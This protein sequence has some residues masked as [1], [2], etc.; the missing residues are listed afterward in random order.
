MY[1]IQRAVVQLAARCNSTPSSGSEDHIVASSPLDY[2]AK[3]S[4]H[5]TKAL[6]IDA[7]T[8]KRPYH[9]LCLRSQGWA[10]RIPFQETL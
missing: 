1:I 10:S 8:S 2:Y 7:A 5:L 9:L 3:P 4:H 6:W